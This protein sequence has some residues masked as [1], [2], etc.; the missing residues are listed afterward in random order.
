[1]FRKIVTGAVT[2]GLLVISSAGAAQ[3]GPANADRATAPVAVAAGESFGI[4]TPL[5]LAIFGAFAV[6]LIALIEAN[7]NDTDAP[8]SP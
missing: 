6:G 8:V 2:A 1:M 3:V 7:E 4:S 5:L